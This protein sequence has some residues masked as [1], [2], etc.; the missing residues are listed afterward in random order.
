MPWAELI[1]CPTDKHTPPPPSTLAAKQLMFDTIWLMVLCKE[2]T[3]SFAT[4]KRLSSATI[5]LDLAKQKNTTKVDE[6]AKDLG[7][8]EAIIS[9]CS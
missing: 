2:K 3:S 5:L 1:T 4:K 7:I 6:K 8:E 9:F